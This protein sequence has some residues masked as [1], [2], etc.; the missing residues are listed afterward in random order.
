LLVNFVFPLK[1][2][3]FFS[4]ITNQ[5]FKLREEACG[6]LNW[7]LEGVAVWGKNLITPKV[8]SINTDEYRGKMDIIR[9][10][11]NER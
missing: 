11:I 6:I 3:T 5:Y 9:N 7:L 8:V 10:F 1:I 2:Y 4:P